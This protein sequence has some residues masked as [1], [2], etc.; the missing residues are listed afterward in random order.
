MP[1]PTLI[2]GT[3]DSGGI[4]LLKFP[5]RS[6]RNSI[7]FKMVTTY[8][9]IMIPIVMLSVYLYNWSYEN[10]REEISRSTEMRLASYLQELNREVGWLELQMFD[11]LEDSE[12]N[13][14]TVSWELMDDVQR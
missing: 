6:W 14:I 13:R 5:A 10:A 9:I 2:I 1:L 4:A 11:L 7:F 12:I 3:V 8:V